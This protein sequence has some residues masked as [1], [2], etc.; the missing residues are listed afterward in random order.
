MQVADASSGKFHKVPEGLEGP[1]WFQCTATCRLEVQVPGGAGRYRSR[2]RSRL[3]A[4][5]AEGCGRSRC[6][7]KCKLQAQVAE[8]SGECCKVVE[9]FGKLRR[10][11]EGSGAGPG[12]RCIIC[13][14]R[15]V[16][17]GFNK[18]PEG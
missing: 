18:V 3:Q 6:R 13:R 4:Q 14:F 15:K 8:G 9:A 11:P 5:V 1:A 17:G 12:A 10:V 7:A 2:A 16:P